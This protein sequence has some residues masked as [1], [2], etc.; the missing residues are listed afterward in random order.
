MK[1]ILDISKLNKI[2]IAHLFLLF[3]ACS[4]SKQNE[5]NESKDI[6]QVDEPK[7]NINEPQNANNNVASNHQEVVKTKTTMNF[8]GNGR[9]FFS[10]VTSIENYKNEKKHGIW[11]Y[12]G[13]DGRQVKVEEYVNGK[14]K[15]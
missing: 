12:Y 15:E 1:D 8:M 3:I 4:S 2:K 9:S 5:I 7:L 10:R 6:I 14:L 13:D 11:I